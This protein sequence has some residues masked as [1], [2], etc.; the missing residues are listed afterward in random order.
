MAAVQ[1]YISEFHVAK[2]DCPAEE[3]MIRMVLDDMEP[4]VALEFDLPARRLMVTHACP[5]AEVLKRLETLNYD[6]RLQGSRELSAAAMTTAANAFA[7][8]DA[9]EARVLKWMLAI[10]GVMFLL[11]VTVGIIGQSTALIADGVDMFADAA[12]YGLA[13]FAVGRSARRK[14]TAAHTAGWLQL[15]LAA[16]VLVEVVRR[17]VYGS[18]PVSGLMMG[19]GLLALIANVSCLLLIHRQRHGGVHM[20]ASWI[21]SAVDVLANTG[22]IL[23]GLLVLL[24]GSRYPDLVIGLVIVLIVLNGSRRI[25]QLKVD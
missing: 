16:S 4:G 11:E 24:T 17:F 8:R 6:T 2:M 21:F 23:A 14:L 5:V 3:R 13:L 7:E 15:I 20:Q 25:L 19:M 18:D 10:N 1:G 12:V 22:V 9:D